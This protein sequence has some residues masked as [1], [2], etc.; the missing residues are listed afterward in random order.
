MIE[1]VLRAVLPI[2]ERL[3]IPYILTGGIAATPHGRP[4]FLS[5]ETCY[6]IL[7]F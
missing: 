7:D 4:R 3:G 6:D 2:L 1:Q 5:H